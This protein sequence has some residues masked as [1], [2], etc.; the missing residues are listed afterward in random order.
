MKTPPNFP[1]ES[2]PDCLQD[3]MSILFVPPTYQPTTTTTTIS[4]PFNAM[5]MKGPWTIFTPQHC[6][7]LQQ[8]ISDETPNGMKACKDLHELFLVY[9]GLGMQSSHGF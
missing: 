7:T 9:P 5:H 8:H 6:D 4:P 2:N 1:T 3:K